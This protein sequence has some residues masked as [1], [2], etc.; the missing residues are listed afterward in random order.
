MW[1]AL[2]A[3]VGD[4]SPNIE[5]LG[6]LKNGTGDLNRVVESEFIDDADRSIVSTG[7]PL[8]KLSP[9]RHFNLLLEP[10]YYLSKGPDFIFGIPASYQ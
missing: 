5:P 2:G 4:Q 1:L 6:V 8:C 10:F 7:Q 9:S 3:G